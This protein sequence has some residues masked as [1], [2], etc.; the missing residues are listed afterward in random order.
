M[1]VLTRLLKGAGNDPHPRAGS[2]EPG[3][4]FSHG[5]PGIRAFP[6][7]PDRKQSKEMQSNQSKEKQVKAKQS[8]A[9]AKQSNAKHSK[10][11][12]IKAKQSKA[13][14]IK[15]KQSKA[16]QSKDHFGVCFAE[17]ITHEFW[18]AGVFRKP[19]SVDSV[20]TLY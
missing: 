3:T 17:P 12:Q 8:K 6:V 9:K 7:P 10:A 20:L 2:R 5:S 14:Q 18:G 16:M 15:A 19:I 13:K 11:K 1:R 4:R